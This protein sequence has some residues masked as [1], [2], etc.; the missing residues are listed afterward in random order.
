MAFCIKIYKIFEENDLFSK[1]G[2]EKHIYL[3]HPEFLFDGF[4]Y[5]TYSKNIN[6]LLKITKTYE[7]MGN[8]LSNIIIFLVS[9]F[10]IM[11]IICIQ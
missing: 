1:F 9:K 5:N 11:S 4:I 7:F 10:I 2:I 3:K 6:L 8:I